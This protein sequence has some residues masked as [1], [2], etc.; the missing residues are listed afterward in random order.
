MANGKKKETKGKGNNNQAIKNARAGKKGDGLYYY[1]EGVKA[2]K[3]RRAAVKSGAIEQTPERKK[4]RELQ[5]LK[6]KKAS[7]AA[8]AQL[9][10]TSAKYSAH[11]SSSKAT[12]AERMKRADKLQKRADRKYK[13]V[14]GNS[15][16]KM[17]APITTRVK[18]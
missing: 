13:R 2:T 16:V 5:G 14:T 8:K 17:N 15:P 4:V 7:K 11:S 10:A 18:R 12:R 1:R 6:N 9:K 3:A